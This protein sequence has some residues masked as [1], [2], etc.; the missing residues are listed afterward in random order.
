MS[1]T[2]PRRAAVIMAGGAGERFWPLS[3]AHYPKQLLKIAGNHSM[4]SESVRRIG[5]L[6]SP[7]DIYVITSKALK[8][9]IEAEAGGI[10]AENVIA[11][12]EGRNTAA[13]LALAA[14]VLD[15]RYPGEDP[16]MIVLTADHFIRD[17][18]TFVLDCVVAAEYAE[19]HSALVT[20]GMKPDRPE[21][22]YGYVE[23]AAGTEANPKVRPVAS[24]R[25]KPNL[26]TARQFLESGNFYWNSGMFVWRN[27]ALK[28]AFAECLP[29]CH[30][31]IEPMSHAFSAADSAVA[32]AGPFG[33]M[34]K[35]S[36][37]YGV[38][39]KAHNVA[40]VLAAFDW[41]DVGTWT[42][43]QRILEPD[44]R[45]NVAFGNAATVNSDNVTVYS[46]GGDEGKPRLVV[47]FN[48]K[49]LV[50]V[51]TPDAIL[52]MPSDSCQE[53]RDVVKRLREEGRTEYL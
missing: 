31:Q 2:P 6:V 1:K 44:G 49:D 26:E 39:E 16:T 19:T 7:E 45:G 11:E 21:T 35:I 41:E 28:R 51:S 3:R 8:P 37:D 38:L 40:V 43:L 46:V 17:T 24:F 52:V 30:A 5:P 4:L 9:A 42:A 48:V 47:G 10:P 29:E 12:P 32:L 33:K 22:G 27:S 15:H 53:V 20:F 36:I 14:A 23:A 18:E 13:C 50:I 25:E 34:P